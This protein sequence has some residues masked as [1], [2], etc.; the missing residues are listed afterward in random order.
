MKLHFFAF[1]MKR[2]R[3]TDELSA[4]F[5]KWYIFMLFSNMLI[6][7]AIILKMV[8]DYE[9]SMNRIQNHMQELLCLQLH[10]IQLTLT[11]L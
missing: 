2:L 1:H 6:L 8:S 5:N 3:W 4:L 10:V 7:V 11:L 9:V